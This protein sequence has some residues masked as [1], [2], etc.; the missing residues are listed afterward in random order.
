MH[1][2]SSSG[3]EMRPSLQVEL[4]AATREKHHA[5]NTAIIARL[6][7]SLPPNADDPLLYAK[8]II[9]FG[10]IYW[11]FETFLATSL[12]N[13]RLD[14]RLHDS[15]QRLYIPCLIRSS[16][17][18]TDIALLKSRL[19][20]STVKE[21]DV[22]AE[23][24]KTFSSRITSSLSARPHVVLSYTWSMYL[25]LFNGGRWIHSQLASAGRDFWGEGVPP[26]S[27]WEFED[28][29][30]CDG[31]LGYLKSLVKDAF[32]VAASRLTCEEK[33]D[34][35]EEAKGLFDLCL[36]MVRFLDKTSTAQSARVSQ[37]RLPSPLGAYA[38]VQGYIG[39]APLVET[40]R[41]YAAS[42]CA[43]LRTTKS[44]AP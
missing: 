28:D 16:R 22:F 33:D 35:I 34:V 27:F 21:L 26:L 39:A 14:S 41:G 12:T 2:Q 6:P 44:A 18:K 23:E 42:V 31:D 15:Y 30:G 43:S 17:L 13:E 9:V 1:P 36:E 3:T 10:Q 19:G 25:A 29:E 7:L 5:L 4:H 37:S 11:A 20:D 40:A 32:S 24:S 38:L 8:G